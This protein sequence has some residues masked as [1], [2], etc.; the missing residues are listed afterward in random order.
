[1]RGSVSHG[2]QP[3]REECPGSELAELEWNIWWLNVLLILVIVVAT[4][5]GAGL[6]MLA[7]ALAHATGRLLP[8]GL[9]QLVPVSSSPSGRSCG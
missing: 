1:M 9:Q 5:T 4:L 7:L 3:H 6:Y 8:T 2:E